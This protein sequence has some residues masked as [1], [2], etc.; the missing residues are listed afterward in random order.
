LVCCC[1]CCAAGMLPMQSVSSSRSCSSSSAERRGQARGGGKGGVL[2]QALAH[3]LPHTCSE[4]VLVQSN[5]NTMCSSNTCFTQKMLY[6]VSSSVK[7]T[8]AELLNTRPNAASC[9]RTHAHSRPTCRRQ[10]GEL[11]CGRL[12]CPL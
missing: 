4:M 6:S 9:L 3:T 10:E 2:T 5:W 7:R 11:P 1:C 12:Q 8:G